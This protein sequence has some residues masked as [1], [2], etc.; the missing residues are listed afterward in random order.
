VKKILALS[1]FVSGYAPSRAISVTHRLNKERANARTTLHRRIN[2]R[3]CN[4]FCAHAAAHAARK[5]DAP[6]PPN[7]IRQRA[8]DE[9]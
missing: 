6:R 1:A 3:I 8:A 5:V 2:A 4:E 9:N 7:K